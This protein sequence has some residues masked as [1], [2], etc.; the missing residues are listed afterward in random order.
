VRRSIAAL[1]IVLAAG[2]Y[3]SHEREPAPVLVDAGCLPVV[4]V[5]GGTATT[6]EKVDLLLL[7]DNSNSMTEEQESLAVALPNIV[8]ALSSGD[9]DLDGV[10]DFPPVGS[11]QVGV[12]TT[13]MGTGGHRLPTCEDPVFGDDGIL[14]AE[15]NTAVAGCAATYPPF[16]RF[17]PEGDVT[18]EEFAA[19]VACVSRAGTGGCGFEQ[20]LE[21]VLKAITP[22]RSPIEFWA[23]GGIPTAGHGDGANV[24][25]VRPD[26]VLVLMVVTDE[27]D[28]SAADPEI[29]NPRSATYTGDLNLR[30][31]TFRSAL[32]DVARYV[33][34]FLAPRPGTPGRLVY[35]TIAGIP[36]DLAGLPATA[37][38]EDARLVER[39]DPRAP[40]RLV[41]SCDVLGRGF[42]FPPRRLLEVGDQLARR[43]ARTIHQ[44]ICQEDFSP[45]VRLIVEEVGRAVRPRCE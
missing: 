31:P 10:E 7:V 30:C 1:V 38:L 18:P 36:P 3:R 40:T 12:I 41:P 29:F 4:E 45:A 33:D 20:P 13:D 11:L 25:F 24:G 8:R 14:K 6:P 27:N 35:A 37:I 21:A 26:S 22:A 32:Y 2:C 28:C 23:P 17:E 39:P 15:G 16:A 42:A 9:V 34:G 5:D 44:S 19:S 43:G